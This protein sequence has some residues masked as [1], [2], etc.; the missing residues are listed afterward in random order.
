M[1]ELVCM[2]RNVKWDG[3]LLQPGDVIAVE[4]TEA[5][6]LLLLGGGSGP[7]TERC[8]LRKV[9]YEARGGR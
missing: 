1:I 6:H 4:S 3:R 9:D 2:Q 8:F 7:P 5:A